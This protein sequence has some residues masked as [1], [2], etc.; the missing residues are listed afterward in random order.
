[1]NGCDPGVRQPNSSASA[2]RQV[3]HIGSTHVEVETAGRQVRHVGSTHAK[4]QRRKIL[5]FN[6]LRVLK[7]LLTQNSER[8]R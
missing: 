8:S 2:G 4:T 3:R 7:I 6:A 1:M 5:I